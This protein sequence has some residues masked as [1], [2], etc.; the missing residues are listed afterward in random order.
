MIV[1]CFFFVIF[2]VIFFHVY[3]FSLV[4]CK[5]RAIGSLPAKGS[6]FRNDLKN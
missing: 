6:L 3:S 1:F 2:F 4:F 5:E